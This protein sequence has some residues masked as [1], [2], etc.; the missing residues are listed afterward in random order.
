MNGEN[1]WCNYV[2]TPAQIIAIFCLNMVNVFLQYMLLNW[3]TLKIKLYLLNGFKLIKENQ[4]KCLDMTFLS[5]S[6][7]M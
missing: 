1:E 5:V 2:I 6:E 7:L 4:M 3:N